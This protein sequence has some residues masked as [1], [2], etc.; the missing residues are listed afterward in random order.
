MKRGRLPLTALR[1][2]EV[3]GRLRSFTLAAEELFVS[4]AAISRQIRELEFQLGRPLFE[5]VHRGVRLTEDGARLLAVLTASFDDID[6]ALAEIAS[7]QSAGHVRISSEPTFAALW[8]VPHLQAFRSQHP[9]IEVVIDSNPRPVEF[10]ASEAEIAI[11][12]S[13]RHSS[14][15]RTQAVRLIGT[16]MVPVAATGLAEGGKPMAEPADLLAHTLLHD[17][18][19]DIWGR[20]FQLAGLDPLERDR[21]PV[22]ADG[23]LVLQ[24]VLRGHGIG[25]ID[26]IFAEEEIASGRIVPLFDVDFPS[27][28]YFLVARDFARLSPGAQRFVEWIRSEFAAR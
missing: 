9:N 15:P 19:R 8:L 14:W 20:W 1:S 28:A 23:S 6:T 11:R 5:R 3:A 17:E 2:F 25:L 24:A 4:Q 22:F 10:R 27:G 26:G 16:R 18:N 21:G 7:R 13:E 12:F